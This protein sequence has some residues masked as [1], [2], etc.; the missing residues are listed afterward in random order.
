[1]EYTD[2][3]GYPC[4][5]SFERGV[6]PVES[7]HVLI[8]AK[9]EDKWLLTEHSERGLEFPGG[10]VETGESLIDAAKREVYEETGGR[11]EGLE[12]FAEYLVLGNPP[13][14]KTVFTGHVSAIDHITRMETNGAV[15]VERLEPD[16]AY[17][18]LMKDEGMKEIMER[19][20]KDGKWKD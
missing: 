20:I 7:R 8:I 18:F 16:N 12:W 19:V 10:K 13:F 9:F 2:L 11:V 15:L 6:F 17:S 5:L 3:N 14:C 1:M 4:K